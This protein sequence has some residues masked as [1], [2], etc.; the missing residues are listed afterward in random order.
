MTICRSDAERIVVLTTALV[1][2]AAGCTTAPGA[3]SG[4]PVGTLGTAPPSGIALQSPTLDAVRADI[5]S[6]FV[7]QLLGIGDGADKV[8]V[9]L[10]STA[11][12]AAAEIVGEYGSAVQVTVGFFPYPPPSAP[13]IVCSLSLSPSASPGS[14]RAVID[15]PTPQ[16]NP[17]VV[18]P[19]KV[20]LTNAGPKKLTIETGQPLAIYLFEPNGTTV[21][22]GSPAAVA[23]TG[24]GFTLLPGASHQ[25]DAVGGTASCDLH[26]GYNLPDGPYVA[27]AAVEIDETTGPDYFWSDP[28]PVQLTTP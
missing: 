14:L 12:A 4:S 13:P 22:G 8:V 25:I 1:L 10:K 27:R 6:R 20:T 15:L 11:T 19:A 26:L 7:D 3:P 17:T 5:Q 9:Q 18:F 16:I 21:V 2:A 28:L 23:G 24:L